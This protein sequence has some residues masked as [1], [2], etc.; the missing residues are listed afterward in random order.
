M[1][2]SAI[3]RAMTI[4]YGGVTVGT[5]QVFQLHGAHVFETNYAETRVAFDVLVQ[6][7]VLATFLANCATLEAAY[8]TPNGDL[9]IA[10]G[11]SNHINYTHSGNTMFNI[12]PSISKIG[13]PADSNNSRLYSCELIGDMPAD[14]TGKAGRQSSRITLSADDAGIQELTVQAVYTA[15]SSNDALTQAQAQFPSYAS[16]LQPSG[17]WDEGVGLTYQYDD[18]NKAVNCLVSYRELIHNQGQGGLNDS[19]LVGST[20]AV[21]LKRSSPNA[22]RGSGAKAL[23]EVT[24]AFDTAV[25]ESSSTDLNGKWAT[26]RVYLVSVAEAQTGVSPLTVT[27]EN[28]AFDPTGNRVSGSLNLIGA[29]GSSLLHSETS[30]AS[31]ETSGEI[32]VPVA[33]GDPFAVDIHQGPA[34]KGIVIQSNIMELAG[35]GAGRSAGFKVYNDAVRRAQGQG[36]RVTLTEAPVDREFEHE[37]MLFSTRLQLRFRSRRVTMRF[38]KPANLAGGGGGGGAGGGGTRVRKN[39]AALDRAFFGPVSH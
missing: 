27:G 22:D 8:R 2:S 33:N 24:V 21:T 12:R 4:S 10:L 35:A 17:T 16:G 38:V 31:S 28:P 11:G 36:Y 34:I 3:T 30:V 19:T 26:T 20:I 37:G 25:L 5:S 1:A 6:N 15:L 39:Q 7:D 18:E 23:A 29:D 32:F 9:Q 14:E 13:G